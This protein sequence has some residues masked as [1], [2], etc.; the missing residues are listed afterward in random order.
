M[1]VVEQSL[2][3]ICR[4]PWRLLL[5]LLKKKR[6]VSPGSQAAEEKNILLQYL[7][8]TSSLTEPQPAS[9]RLSCSTQTH[10][11]QPLTPPPSF[12][13]H[14]CTLIRILVTSYLHHCSQC[15]STN[16]PDRETWDSSSVLF[17]S[18][19]F[20]FFNLISFSQLVRESCCSHCWLPLLLLFLLPLGFQAF[21][22]SVCS[23]PLSPGAHSYR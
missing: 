3:N 1:A 15:F 10:F 23:F 9:I 7:S 14:V 22:A 16:T 17:L 18:C 20:L 8:S 2:G 6:H 5:K 13:K 19:C 12:S 4:K 11:V 21:T